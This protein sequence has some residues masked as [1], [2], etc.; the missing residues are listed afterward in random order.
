MTHLSCNMTVIIQTYVALHRSVLCLIVLTY[1]ICNNNGCMNKM[2]RPNSF[3]LL[4]LKMG[5]FAFN[6]ATLENTAFGAHSEM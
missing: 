4:P 5:V 6:N 3:H 2:V 1:S